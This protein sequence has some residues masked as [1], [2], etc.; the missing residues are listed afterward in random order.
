MFSPSLPL[1]ALALWCLVPAGT[2][3]AGSITYLVTANTNSLVGSSGYLDFQF[4]PNA[5]GAASATAAVTAFTSNGTPGA[6]FFQTG[7]QTGSLPGTLTFNNGTALNELT[8]AFTYG[9]T[10]MYDVTLSGTAVGGSAPVGSTFSFTLFDNN[11][12]PYSTGP[13]GAAVTINIDPNGTTSDVAYT[14]ASN[15]GPTTTVTP[16][17]P[18]PEPASL[19]Q[20]CLGVGTLLGWFALRR[21]RASAV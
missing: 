14:P 21:R 11:G 7:N 18:V 20:L 1:L 17:N 3:R 8:Q 2:A 5:S 6:V 15:G 19:G 12:N 9:T 10:L 4:N 16:V 13:G